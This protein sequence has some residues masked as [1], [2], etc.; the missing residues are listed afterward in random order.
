MVEG[1]TVEGITVEGITIA[2]TGLQP[3]RKGLYHAYPGGRARR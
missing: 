3:R 2:A 1:I